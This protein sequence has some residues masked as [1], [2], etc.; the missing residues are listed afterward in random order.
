MGQKIDRE[1]L[2]RVAR[3]ARVNLSEKEIETI[4]PQFLEMLGTFKKIAEV[5]V[6][7]EKP[8][9]HPVELQ[10]VFRE[11]VVEESMSQE[12]ALSNSRDKKNGYFKGPKVVL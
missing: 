12:E 2:L 9:F 5:D 1:F 4:L 8:A 7:G 3:N 10:N 11:D 6:K